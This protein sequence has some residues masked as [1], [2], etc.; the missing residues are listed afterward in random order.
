MASDSSNHLATQQSIKAYVDSQVTAQDLDF[1]G[2]SGGALNI[3]LD[4]EVLTF[5]GGTG[6]DTSGSGNAI[7]FAI[8]ST[9]STLTGTQILT[10]K[11]L[12]SAVLN[13]NISG[14][15]IKDEDNMESDSATHLATQQSIKAYVD[16]QVT[17]QDLDFQGDSGGAQS[18]DLDSETLTLAGGT[19]ISTSGSGNTITFNIDS[20]VVTT[21]TGT[22]TLTNKTLTEPILNGTISGTAIKDEDNMASN[23]ATH[24]ATQ[25]SIKA[26]VDSVAQGLHIK[27][28][29]RVATSASGTLSTS[30]ANGSGIDG[31]IL[32]TGDRILIKDQTDAKEN[33]IY[34]VTSG[35]PNRSTDMDTGSTANSD[36]TFISEGTVNGNHGFVCTSD[37]NSSTVGQHD[38]TFVQFSGAGQITAGNGLSKSGNELSVNVDNSSIEI[39]SDTIKVKSLG[40]QNSHLTGSITNDKLVNKSVSFGGISLDLGGTDDT[41]AFDL[42]D[43]INYPTGSLDGTIS[44]S[45]LAGSISNDKLA[46]SITNEKLAGSISNDKLA[47]SISNDKLAGSIENNKLA[48]K[49]VSYGGVSLDLGGTDDT[50]AFDLRDATDYPASSLTGV[51]S[52][53]KGGTNATSF[54]DKSVIIT[55]DSGTDTLSAANMSTNGQ[56]LIG[57]TSGPTPATLTQGSNVTITNGDGTISIASTQLTT[58]QVQDI[59]GAMFSSNT[60]TGISASY[61]DADGTI[62]LVVGTLNQ[63]TSGTAATASALASTVKIGGVSFDGSSDI[64]LPGVNATGNQDTSGTAATASALAS[65]VKIGGASF[66]GSSDIDLPGVNK[67]GN[68]DTSGNADTSTLASTVTVTD[69]TADTNFPVVFHNESNGLLDDTG[70]LTYNPNHGTLNFSDN[71]KIIFGDVSDPANSD[72]EI[73]HNGSHSYIQDKGT[74]DLAIAASHLRF[75]NGSAGKTFI[76]CTDGGSVELYHDNSKKFETTSDGITVGGSIS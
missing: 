13:D 25:Q 55:Q 69:S 38:L 62:D 36:F 50:P 6:I 46:G 72:L 2:D 8:D 70:S 49:S 21:L 48:N 18:I 12:T 5:T 29:C 19:G 56:L 57:G 35:T 59:V 60:E 34:I 71:K 20:A 45:Q 73:Y 64:N 28:S 33:G 68:Q 31:V 66:D 47:G 51:L 15:S 9:V 32:V 65:S 37:E 43:A 67:A 16:S 54:D 39:L 63:D 7:T 40:I 58:E 76:L 53:S 74:G 30:F 61:Q 10:N 52:V 23:S 42:S 17:A 27:E 4:S 24:L 1:Q 26:Y 3:D 22:Q 44:N 41:P 11:T 75:M 14:T